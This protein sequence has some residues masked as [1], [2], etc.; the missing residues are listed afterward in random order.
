[1][2]RTL[3][4]HGVHSASQAKDIR[5][6]LPIRCTHHPDGFP[7]FLSC[8]SIAA[9]DAIRSCPC[10]SSSQ[11]PTVTRSVSGEPVFG[12]AGEGKTCRNEERTLHETLDHETR[13]GTSGEGLVNALGQTVVR[14][15]KESQWVIRA[16]AGRAT[17]LGQGLIEGV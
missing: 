15:E 5:C 14:Q 4:L 7:P 1:M 8:Q 11:L 10:D 6:S 9:R 17:F 2:A 12:V 3:T 16:L 13:T